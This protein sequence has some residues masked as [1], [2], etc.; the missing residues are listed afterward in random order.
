[1]TLPNQADPDTYGM[2]DGGWTNYDPLVDPTTDVDAE[3]G[4]NDAFAD[5]AAMTHTA[6][7]GWAR[8]TA[9]TSPT[10]ATPNGSEAV[11]GNQSPVVPVPAHVTTGE[12]TLTFPTTV[13]DNMN[14][15]YT[16]NLRRARVSCEGST[17][18]P[19][20]C[21]VTA[22]NVVTVWICNSS[23]SPNDATGVIFHVEAG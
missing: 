7:R 20:Q 8:F 1:M 3:N 2:P 12:Y 10:L 17:F 16:V 18:Y 19:C 14:V 15:T 4:G 13:T 21:A 11:W 23:F 9:G 22:P 5:I 6:V